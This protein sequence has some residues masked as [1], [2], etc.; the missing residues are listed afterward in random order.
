MR[1]ALGS[2]GAKGFQKAGERPPLNSFV[3]GRSNSERS[4]TAVFNWKRSA[5]L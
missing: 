4:L 2:I 3:S 1:K 5:V